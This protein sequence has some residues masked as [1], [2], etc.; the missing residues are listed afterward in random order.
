MKQQ[1]MQHPLLN[2]DQSSQLLSDVVSQTQVEMDRIKI[3]SPSSQPS[4][5]HLVATAASDDFVMDDNFPVSGDPMMSLSSTGEVILPACVATVTLS[6]VS[7]MI[8]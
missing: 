6:D 2:G 1:G 4:V 8:L 7:D 3:E 5:T